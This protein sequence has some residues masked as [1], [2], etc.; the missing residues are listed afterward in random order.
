M[1]S[2]K[3]MR[4]ALILDETLVADFCFQRWRPKTLPSNQPPRS[5]FTTVWPATT[6]PY[7]LLHSRMYLYS[8]AKYLIQSM[9][10]TG[11][12]PRLHKDAST[13][14]LIART[15]INTASLLVTSVVSKD[16]IN[17]LKPAE[18]KPVRR[19]TN[20]STGDPT[21]CLPI[22]RSTKHAGTD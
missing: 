19:P 9:P 13:N 11:H 8:D 20:S 2:I 3:K 10:E 15:R 7:D 16:M 4:F 5:S 6:S 22:E 17:E 18:F 21:N 14:S 1:C 12:Q